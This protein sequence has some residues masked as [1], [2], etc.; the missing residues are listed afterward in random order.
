MLGYAAG[1]SDLARGD[2]QR[3]VLATGDL[4][5]RDVDGF[6]RLTGRLARFAKLYGKRINLAGVEAE[7]EKVFSIRTAALDGG[8]RLRVL[9][10]GSDEPVAAKVR[11]YLADWLA[12]PPLALNVV[13]ITQIPL[14]AS[15][16]KD[17][18][19]LA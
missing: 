19:A 17:Y 3:G 16:K 14:T 15:G 1:P 10:E 8:D 2:D 4:A 11:A 12:V 13:L 18:K 6:F 7:V 5:E 9:L